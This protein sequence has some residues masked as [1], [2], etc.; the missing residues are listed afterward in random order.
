MIDAAQ[1]LQPRRAG[2]ATRQ[3]IF[4]LVTNP[5]GGSRTD[6]VV[7]IRSFTVNSLVR[8]PAS[9]APLAEAKLADEFDSLAEQ[10]HGETHLLSGADIELHPAYQRIIGMGRP[11]LPFI[12]KNMRAFGGHWFWALEAISGENP[13]RDTSRVSEGIAAWLRW[14]RDQH[15]I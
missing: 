8:M 6:A 10:W 1:F 4:K 14:G 2:G 5:N 9:P 12:L 11:A 7:R 13:A 15:L 3:P